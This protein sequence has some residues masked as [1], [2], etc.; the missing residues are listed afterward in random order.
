MKKTKLI[1]S[2]GSINE[3]EKDHGPKAKVIYFSDSDFCGMEEVWSDT[4]VYPDHLDLPF[5][6]SL[7]SMIVL[8]GLCEVSTNAGPEYLNDCSTFYSAKEGDNQHGDYAHIPSEVACNAMK[9]RLVNGNTDERP[10]RT[11]DMLVLREGGNN[12]TCD[13]KILKE[14]QAEIDPPYPTG[15][16]IQVDSTTGYWEIFDQPNFKGKRHYLYQYEAD[17]SHHMDGSGIYNYDNF[18]VASAR[19]APYVYFDKHLLERVAVINRTDASIPC[20]LNGAGLDS[21]R[22]IAPQEDI[23]FELQGGYTGWYK[24][25]ETGQQVLKVHFDE[26]KSLETIEF[27]TQTEW[28]DKETGQQL[29]L[30][31]VSHGWYRAEP[32]GVTSIADFDLVVNLTSDGH[33]LEIHLIPSNNDATAVRGVETIEG[34]G[35]TYSAKLRAKGINSVDDLLTI[36]AVESD[37]KGLA[38]QIGVS[39]KKLLTWVNHADL[40]QVNGID[41]QYAE[42]LELSG[43]DTVPELAQRNAT[44][45]LE[46]MTETNALKGVV[47]VLPALADVESWITAAKE[48]PRVIHY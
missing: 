31:N 36:G 16:A 11:K 12:T 33:K 25:P 1:T 15:T 14:A 26:L 30:Y 40:M 17:S 7:K 48:L 37:R 28:Y 8:R 32:L 35:S 24:D 18:P 45:L 20:N 13:A 21:A 43:V 39:D 42:L 34:I 41:H 10:F 29:H 5:Y 4:A 19:P 23:T 38:E 6:G 47:R 46:K 2:E 22:T 44:N 9:L 3:Q 27:S